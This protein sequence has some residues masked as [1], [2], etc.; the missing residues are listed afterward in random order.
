MRFYLPRREKYWYLLIVGLAI[1]GLWFAFDRLVLGPRIFWPGLQTIAFSIAEP[2]V[3]RI[4]LLF[5]CMSMLS[6][7]LY[8][9]QEQKEN[10][11]QNL[12][13][14][15]FKRSRVVKNLRQ[16]LQ[17][18]FLFN[19]LNS[20]SALTGGDPV[21]ARHMIQQLSDLRGTLRKDD[22][23]WSALSGRNRTPEPLSLK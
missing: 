3:W 21:R 14:K 16:Q 15:T 9:Q 19:S 8:N 2:Q 1:S 12:K 10:G 20:I 6:L 11:K 13:R 17:P 23:Q 7:P 22:Q 4:V 5:N 18:H